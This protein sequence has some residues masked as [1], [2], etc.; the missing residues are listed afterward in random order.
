MTELEQIA[1]MPHVKYFRLEYE[2]DEV[3][4]MIGNE[5]MASSDA[6][7]KLP[8]ICK[9]ELRRDEKYPV[10]LYVKMTECGG[11]CSWCIGN[12]CKYYTHIETNDNGE[13][14]IIYCVFETL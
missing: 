10:A 11:F 13:I 1:S 6:C 8:I 4:M 5:I 3:H 12:K 14:K 7:L 2:G 9:D